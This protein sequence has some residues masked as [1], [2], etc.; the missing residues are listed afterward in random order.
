MKFKNGSSHTRVFFEYTGVDQLSFACSNAHNLLVSGHAIFL[1]VADFY[2]KKGQQC[3]RNMQ[4]HVQ[5]SGVGK[6][7]LTSLSFS[8][9]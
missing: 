5:A 9:H 2:V 3:A 1:V 4:H 8:E 6:Q 7:Q